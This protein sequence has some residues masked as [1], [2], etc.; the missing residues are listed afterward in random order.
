MRHS[1]KKTHT[2]KTILMKLEIPSVASMPSL[3]PPLN[4]E[5][6]PLLPARHPHMLQCLTLSQFFKTKK[7]ESIAESLILS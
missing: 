4:R 5:S 6:T 1:L 2:K 7:V 3:E